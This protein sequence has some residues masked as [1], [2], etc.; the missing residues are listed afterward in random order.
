MPLKPKI[1]GIKIM[2]IQLLKNLLLSLFIVFIGSN[3]ASSAD[4]PIIT[5][6]F[7]PPPHPLP[8]DELLK[9]NQCGF[10]YIIKIFENGHVEYEG[11][12]RVKVPGKRE[13]QMD[14]AT[15]KALIK[16]FEA[17]HFMAADEHAWLP[18]LVRSHRRVAVTAIRFRQGNQ[19]AT[20][21]DN[22]PAPNLKNEI[23][24]ATKA[25]RWGVNEPS[26]CIDKYKKYIE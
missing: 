20:V 2:I 5:L 7:G 22:Y 11:F 4:R 18:D 13:Y 12:Y 26:F 10:A 15:L 24:R 17:A 1:T 6:S 16:K 23:I 8:A 25:E 14:K 21:F 9:A 19:E 3:S